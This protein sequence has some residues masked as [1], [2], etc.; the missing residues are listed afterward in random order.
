M[1]IDYGREVT[2]NEIVIKARVASGDTHFTSCVAEFSD[3]TKVVLNLTNSAVNQY[4]DV[5]SIKT[6]YVKLTNFEV[7]DS[8]KAVAITELQTLGVENLK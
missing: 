7:A 8:S 1:Q 3:G 2:V 6:T 5:G 4:F